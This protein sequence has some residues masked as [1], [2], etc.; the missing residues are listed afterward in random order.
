MKNSKTTLF[1]LL[2]SLSVTI[3]SCKKEDVIPEEPAPAPVTTPAG[4]TTPVPANADGVMWAIKSSSTVQG[5]TIEIGTAVGIFMNG[6]TDLVD[7]GAVSV[8]SQNLT[9]ASNNAYT[10]NPSQTMPTGLDFSSAADWSVAGGSGHAGFTYDASSLV[11]PTGSAITSSAT[12]NRANGYTLT[13]SA[14]SGADSTLFVIG[15]VSKTVSGSANS[16]TFS[17]SELSGL[18]AGSSVVMIVP[19][20][21]MQATINGKNYYFGKERVNQLA[22]TIE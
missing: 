20:K 9:K 17:A 8:N 11:F 21:L 18:S 4:S 22:V 10:F 1:V 14:V 3:S 12:V 5:F 15:N 6:T 16:C 2:C 7:V 13:S 19:Y